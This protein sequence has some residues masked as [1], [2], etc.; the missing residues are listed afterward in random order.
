MAHLDQIGGIV[1]DIGQRQC[2]RHILALAVAALVPGPDPELPDLTAI[3]TLVTVQNL[4]R[5]PACRHFHRH[6]RRHTATVTVAITVTLLCLFIGV[7]GRSD[8]LLSLSAA[9]FH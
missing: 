3:G 7:F 8:C 5:A 2:E 1:V 6:D 9:H 4:R